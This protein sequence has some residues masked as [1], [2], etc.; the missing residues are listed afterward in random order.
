MKDNITKENAS[1]ISY[2]TYDSNLTKEVIYHFENQ[3]FI[4]TVRLN[5][6]VL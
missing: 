5:Y 4:L 3:L 2:K 6:S 1:F